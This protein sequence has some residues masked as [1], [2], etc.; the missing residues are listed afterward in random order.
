MKKL[1]WVLLAV[2][3]VVVIVVAVVFIRI[4]SIVRNTVETQSAKQLDVPVTLAGA[5]VGI[6]G[7]TLE[8]EK[9]TIGSPQGFKAPAMFSVDDVNVAVSYGQ[10]RQ[11][12]I[13][14]KSIEIEKPVLVLEHGGG[15]KFNIQA[16]MEKVKQTPDPQPQEETKPVHVIIDHLRINGATVALRPGDLSGIPLLGQFDLKKLDIKEEYRLTLPAIDIT[17]IGSGEGAQNGAAI[18]EVVMQVTSAMAAKAAESPELPEPVRVL[19]S[20]N[21]DAVGDMMKA[22]FQ[23]QIGKVAEDLTKKLPGDAG[24]ALDQTLKDV[25]KPGADPG[26]AIEKNLQEGLGGLLGEKDKDNKDAPK[27]QTDPKQPK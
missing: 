6:W 4:D 5:D 1:K 13:R 23:Q 9:Y 14:I 10:L 24:K 22:Q 3:L 2:V 17:N 20:G 27:E 25:T 16:L 8:L 11:D 7:G 15:G 12:P 26:K 21:L 18:K 19:L